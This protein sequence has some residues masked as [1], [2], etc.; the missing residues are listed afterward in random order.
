MRIPKGFYRGVLN[1][2]QR[3]VCKVL[4]IFCTMCLR[5]PCITRYVFEDVLSEGIPAQDV[6][7]A[8]PAQRPVWNGINH[9]GC[10]PLKAPL[11][12]LAGL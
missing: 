4:H 11:Q 3:I 2:Y 10:P 6:Q 5:G 8:L 1:L 7:T 9:T 12:Q